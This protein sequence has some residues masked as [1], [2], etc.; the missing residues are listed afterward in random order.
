MAWFVP[1]LIAVAAMGVG[2]VLAPKTK[3]QKPDQAEEMDNPTAEAGVPIT[4]VFGQV[5]IKSPNTL[6]IG[7]KSIRSFEINS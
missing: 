4:V 5:T 3:S 1:F 2:Y 7:E 6:W